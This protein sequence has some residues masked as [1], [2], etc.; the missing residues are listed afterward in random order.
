MSRS[1]EG[2]VI[3]ITGGASGMGFATAKLLIER[4]AKVSIADI[5]P[6][7]ET[8]AVELA[9]PSGI[10]QFKGV[11]AHKVNSSSLVDWTELYIAS[12]HGVIGLTKALALD[13]GPVGVRINAVCPGM[14]HTPMTDLLIDSIGQDALDGY[15]SRNPL[16]RMAEPEE[17]ARMILFLLSDDSSY[18]TRSAQVA[19]DGIT[20]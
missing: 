7:L 20:A 9:R 15:V 1:M 8:A 5:S 16:P 12:K 14:I 17:V 4:G 19:D 13:Y 2:K 11:Y 3:A 18:V 6:D 10:D